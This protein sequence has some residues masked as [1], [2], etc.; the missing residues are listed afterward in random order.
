MGGIT[1]E[2]DTGERYPGFQYFQTSDSKWLLEVLTD[3]PT[4][5]ICAD[6]L[7]LDL[8]PL[9]KIV[10]DWGT[11][12]NGDQTWGAYEEAAW[13]SPSDII[14]CIERFI[15]ALDST[16]DVYRQLEEARQRRGIAFLN[17]SGFTDEDLS[18]GQLQE[19][20]RSLMRVVILAQERGA[21]LI[22]LEGT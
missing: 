9:R 17:L 3:A 10:V 1:V 2:T 19:G 11:P 21:T 8:S 7:Q 18:D 15:M 14:G 20:L 16:P 4:L 12:I 13:Q 22:R 6:V 5:P